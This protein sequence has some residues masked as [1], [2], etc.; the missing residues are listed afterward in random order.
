M[1]KNKGNLNSLSSEIYKKL[2]DSITYGYLNPGEKIMASKLEKDFGASRTPIRE[3]IKQLQNAGYVE[4]IHN[5]GA[6][7]KKTSLDEVEKIY[8]VLFVV[9]GYAAK[10]AVKNITDQEIDELKKLNNILKEL[11][12]LN[13]YREYAEKNNEFHYRISQTSG[14]E[15]L[16]NVIY[17]L[18]DRVYRYRFLGIIIPSHI[19]EF[20]SDHENIIQALRERDMVKTEENMRQHIRRLK[21]ILVNV[22]RDFVI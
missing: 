19:E 2:R 18:R 4:I 8:D 3:A 21:E 15:F 11:K 10:L 5:K 16:Q 17:E 14:N 22:L 12:D 7:V 9:E 1:G 6:Y 13:R 20:I